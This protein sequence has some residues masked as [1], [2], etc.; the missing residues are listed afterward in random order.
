MAA[1]LQHKAPA[2]C[3][4]LSAPGARNHR[5]V[6]RKTDHE[7]RFKLDQSV[8]AD[9]VQCTGHHW[10]RMMTSHP[11]DHKLN[12]VLYGRTSYQMFEPALVVSSPNFM[13]HFSIRFLGPGDACLVPDAGKSC[14]PA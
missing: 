5:P 10:A 9:H 7:L 14:D 8:G 13:G 11:I 6:A 2:Q 4:R 3:P 1:A 12:A